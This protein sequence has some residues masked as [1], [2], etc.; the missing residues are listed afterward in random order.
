MSTETKPSSRA[1]DG[2]G[3]RIGVILA[4]AGSAVGLGNFLRFP[5]QAASNGGGAFMIP[6]FISLLI[7]G[8]PL[9]WAEWTMGRYGGRRGFNSAPGIFSA[10]W[11]HPAAKYLGMLAVLIPLMIYMYYVLIEAWCLGY[12]FN[13]LIG[14]EKLTASNADFG[15]FFGSYVGI[16]QDGVLMSPK[17][18]DGKVN[19]FRAENFQLLGILIFTFGVNFALIY[20]GVSKGIET[21]CKIAIPLMVVLALVVLVRVMTLPPQPIP[22]DQLAAAAANSTVEGDSPTTRSVSDGLGFMWNPD[23]SKLLEPKTWLAAAGQIFFSLSVGFGVIINYASYL[24]KEDD[25]ALGSLTA[26]S[27]NEFFEVCLGGLITIPAAFIFLG[28]AVIGMGTFAVGFNALPEVFA[29]MPFGQLFGFLWFFMLF[30]AAMTSSISML[31]PAIA[32]LEEGFGLKRQ[33]SVAILGLIT[34]MG[35]GF[36][37]YFSK[38]LTALDTIDFW[39]GTFLIFVLALIQAI[40][41]GWLFGLKRGDREMHEGAHIKV[42]A[43]VQFLLKYVVPVYMLVIFVS[44]IATNVFTKFETVG[45]NRAPI[46]VATSVTD[47]FEEGA[48]LPASIRETLQE[49]LKSR[50]IDESLP[51]DAVLSK[52]RGKWSIGNGPDSIYPEYRFVKTEVEPTA[53]E[54]E[55][56]PEEVLA[57]QKRVPG[58]L[59]GILSNPSAMMSIL[60]IGV[61]S[62]FMLVMIH[63]AGINWAESGR[64]AAARTY[65]DPAAETPDS[66]E[67]T[68]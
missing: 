23:F 49:Q 60:F 33:D 1:S 25:I 65:D 48:A 57:L 19:A 5:G 4:V 63:I 37:F 30:V 51:T 59:E 35:T 40:L 52:E 38:G 47:D 46:A 3:S 58:R 20:R 66:I 22:E 7:L 2:W 50:E 11:H 56:K 44:F 6:Y 18:A 68:P 34:A 14:N 24:K 64:L 62:V 17:G 41:Y 10:I 29:K 54:S 53:G 36:V 67:V 27:M 12:A 55:A 39:V 28:T 43:L 61:V 9:A 15:A 21:F 31:Q 45:G 8:I 13:Y 32:F 26:C 16:E 42:P